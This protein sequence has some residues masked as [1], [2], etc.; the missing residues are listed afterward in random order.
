MPGG[1]ST[2]TGGGG[3]RTA[4][5]GGVRHAPG[6]AGLGRGAKKLLESGDLE[7]RQDAFRVGPC[8]APPVKAPGCAEGGKRRHARL[9]PTELA[10]NSHFKVSPAVVR[11]HAIS[12]GF[13]CRHGLKREAA[14]GVRADGFAQSP[15]FEGE[16]GRIRK[17]RKAA[18]IAGGRQKIGWKFNN[19]RWR[20][21][22]EPGDYPVSSGRCGRRS[23]SSLP[24]SA[25][26]VTRRGCRH[27]P[28]LVWK[29]RS[30]RTSEP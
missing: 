3:R 24:L 4:P 22:G 18:G 25:W 23:A 16:S 1:G 5:R 14:A 17:M 28:T 9:P 21:G 30:T 27:S 11:K 7:V 29:P 6:P 10:A 15:E 8:R 19:L 2:T 20:S 26:S 12:L 13:A